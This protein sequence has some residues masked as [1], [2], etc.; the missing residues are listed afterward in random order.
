MTIIWQEI[1]LPALPLQDGIS[2]L[3]D[4]DTAE[5]SGSNSGHV[6]VQLLHLPETEEQL[7]D[8][9][10]FEVMSVKVV[11]NSPKLRTSFRY[12]FWV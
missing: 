1:E 9:L 6:G 3:A 4:S 12:Y 10:F 8:S 5:G 11:L 2:F 7:L